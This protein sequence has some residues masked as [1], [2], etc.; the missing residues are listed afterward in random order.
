[1]EFKNTLAEKDIAITVEYNPPRGSQINLS[2]IKEVSDIIDGVNVTDCP[3]AS[4]R[5]NSI[6]ASYVIQNEIGLPAIFNLTCR[7]R[8]VL[9]LQSDLLGA[10]GLGL[11][12]V[13]AI[14]GDAIKDVPERNVYH[15]N[16]YQL[17]NLISNL[18]NGKNIDNQNID[19]KTDFFIGVASNVYSKVNSNG[20]RNRLK[21]KYNA[22]SKFVVTQPIYSAESLDYFLEASKDIDILKIIGIFPVTNVKTALYLDKYVQ[23]ISIPK[24]LISRLETAKNPKIE[25]FN[26]AE[27]VIEKILSMGYGRYIK[28]IHLMRFN[29]KFAKFVYNTINRS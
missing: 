21:R 6:A 12:S 16:T 1:M 7:D 15:T 25:G 9:A 8:N 3:M 18:N 26:F 19:S 20:I 24:K 27:S 28:G 13:L 14:G 5:M 4:L 2:S 10:W 23:G 11:R 22:G 17:I 29:K